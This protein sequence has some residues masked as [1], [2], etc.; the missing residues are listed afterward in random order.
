MTLAKEIAC[1]LGY[2]LVILVGW[3][4]SLVAAVLSHAADLLDDLSYTLLDEWLP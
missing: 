1:C 2:F 3:P 4:L